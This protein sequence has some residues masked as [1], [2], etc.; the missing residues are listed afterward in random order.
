MKVGILRKL[1]PS[2]REPEVAEEWK[3]GLFF[4]IFNEAS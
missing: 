3:N 4:W 1:I 2:I